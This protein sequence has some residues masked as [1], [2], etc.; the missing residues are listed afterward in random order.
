MRK[1]MNIAEAKEATKRLFLGVLTNHANFQ[2]NATERGI[3]EHGVVGESEAYAKRDFASGIHAV[4]SVDVRFPHSESSENYRDRIIARPQRLYGLIADSDMEA[5]RMT[6]ETIAFRKC[7]DGRTVDE[8]LDEVI[9]QVFKRMEES[10][11]DPLKICGGVAY[12]DDG[13]RE[14]LG[15][16]EIA[17]VCPDGLKSAVPD[18]SIYSGYPETL[19]NNVL[20]RRAFE[21][22]NGTRS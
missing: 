14:L 4:T 16:T 3:S 18:R 17:D 13:V 12:S 6:P 21:I 10:G 15:I 7:G 20:N 5:E 9:E 19:V 2:A 1:P 11:V 8:A 22:A